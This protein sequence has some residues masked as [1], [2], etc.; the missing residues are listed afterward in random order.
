MPEKKKVV[1]VGAGFAGINLA[2]K[3]DPKYFEVLI[4]DKINH[5]QFQPLFYQVATSQL[6]PSTISFPIRYLFKRKKH[7]RVRVTKVKGVDTQNKLLKTDIG[8]QPYDYLVLA[9]GCKTN[10]FGNAEIEKNTLALKS[11]YDAISVRNH[12]LQIF[13][14]IINQG[15]EAKEE[16]YNL[17]IVG[18][19]PTGVEM[20]GALAEIRNSI[21]PQDYHRI[22]FSKLRIILIEGSPNTLNSMSENSHKYSRKYL[23]EMGVEILTQTIVKTYDGKTL[24]TQDGK[25]FPSKTVIW[26]AGVKANSLE[27]LDQ[28]LYSRS[29]RILVDR[30]NQIPQLKHVYVLGDQ[31]E[32]HTEK[33]PY[34][35]PQLANVAINQALLL[36][37]NLKAI[38]ENKELLAFEYNDK[39]SMATIGRNKA[40]VDLPYLKFQ[41]FFA[42]LTWMALHLWL[43]LTV[44]NKIIV[45]IN[46]IWAYFSRNTSLRI[47]LK[48]PDE[49]I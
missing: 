43:I 4:V 35:H 36:A 26:S 17:I 8:D 3:L 40:V 7:V 20:A 31:A 46:W 23:E 30:F 47:I 21:L 49:R 18:A 39:G 38:E 6:E 41:G 12:I 10:Y 13:E 28:E 15:E 2:R 5:H 33:Y 25:E 27:G 22:D 32:M 16:L 48:N 9:M 45:F 44:R 14:E 1:I 29:G 19:G 42:W 37:K 34:G 24:I 11:T